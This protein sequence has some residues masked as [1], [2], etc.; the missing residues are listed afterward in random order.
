[1]VGNTVTTVEVAALAE[2]AAAPELVV[3][4][5]VDPIAALTPAARLVTFG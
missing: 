1:V 5:D 4:R 3:V 2:A